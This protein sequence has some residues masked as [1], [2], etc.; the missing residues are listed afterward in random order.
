MLLRRAAKNQSTSGCGIETVLLATDD[1][2]A[3]V[4]KMQLQGKV[5]MVGD[6]VNDVPALAAANVCIAID[7]HKNVSLAVMSAD[8]V[9]LGDDAKDLITILRLSLKMGGI[10]KQNYTWAM[11]FN[12]IGLTLATLGALTPIVAALFH[13]LSS[14]FEVV[15]ASRLYFTGIENSPVGPLFQKMDEITR[16]KQMSPV[17]PL[18]INSENAALG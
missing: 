4:K 10:I 3:V 5:A 14:V 12:A 17:E 13:H 16:P 6:G 15:N 7:G 1:K 9:I 18:A 11:G 8:I 2:T